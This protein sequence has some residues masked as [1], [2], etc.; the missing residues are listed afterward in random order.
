MKNGEF[1]RMLLHYLGGLAAA[2]AEDQDLITLLGELQRRRTQEALKGA[3]IIGRLLAAGA[4]IRETDDG[5]FLFSAD[6]RKISEFPASQIP[7]FVREGIIR[8]IR[9][10]S[11]GVMAQWGVANGGN[12]EP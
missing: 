9:R 10:R 4:T 1:Y 5:C 8:R 2:G 11:T 3:R 12:A 6:G 7:S